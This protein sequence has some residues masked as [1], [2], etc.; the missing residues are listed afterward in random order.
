MAVSVSQEGSKTQV[1]INKS[2]TGVLQYYIL[3]AVPS[4]VLAEIVNG[5]GAPVLE[6]V[7]TAHRA[8]AT[9]SGVVY[10]VLS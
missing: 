1:K 9:P 10:S 4:R 2:V 3:P 5:R 8:T 6:L 7:T